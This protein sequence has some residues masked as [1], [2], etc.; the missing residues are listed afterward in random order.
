M[1]KI[2]LNQVRFAL[3][4]T[5]FQINQTLIKKA[6]LNI[7]KPTFSRLY[8]SRPRPYK[9]KTESNTRQV[10]PGRLSCLCTCSF[11]R[12][13][14]PAK[15]LSPGGCVCFSRLLFQALLMPGDLI[16]GAPQRMAGKMALRPFLARGA[17]FPGGPEP[18]ASEVYHP[19]RK[20]I[21]GKTSA[22]HP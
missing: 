5:T 16:G 19:G 10:R 1:S 12:A 6:V 11:A 20:K 7:C 22:S 15:T 17:V 13:S 8:E 14:S 21:K 4:R 9:Q 3:F 18:L 2:M